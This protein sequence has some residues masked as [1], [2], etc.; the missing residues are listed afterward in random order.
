MIKEKA[1]AKLNLNLHILANPSYKKKTGY[2]QIHFINS[3]LNLYDELTFEAQPK[4]IS[5]ICNVKE[6]Q[7]KEN[8]VYRAASLL[9]KEIGNSQLGVKITLLKKIPV[10]A[11]L[12]G[13]SSDAAMTLR[14]LLQL[15]NVKKKATMNKICS[16]LGSD[17][18]YSM[19]GGLCEITGIGNKVKSIQHKPFSLWAVLVTPAVQ[20]PSTSWMYSH[21]HIDKIG[22][23]VYKLRNMKKALLNG[24]KNIFLNSI[25]N[26]FDTT[27]EHLFPEVRSIKNSLHKNG[28]LAEYVAGSGLTVV[29]IYD[30]EKLALMAFN[31]LQVQYKTLVWTN[32]K[33]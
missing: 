3:E 14:S 18:F 31:N 8:L 23:H 27:I 19:R 12:G 20:K 15:W 9:K 29:G 22:N 33:S 2:F 28:A 30:T 16:S 25:Y 11:G 7:T 5:L 13:G 17:V 1:F 6:L 21:L 10:C 4:K 32:I 24:D 26:D